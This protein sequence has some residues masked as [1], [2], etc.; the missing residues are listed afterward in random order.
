MSTVNSRGHVGTVSY[1]FHTV[2][3]KPPRGRLPVLSAQIS[4]FKNRNRISTLT[5]F[6]T[7]KSG[8]QFH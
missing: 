2:P 1:P 8:V 7:N 5:M 4:G 6:L 3:D